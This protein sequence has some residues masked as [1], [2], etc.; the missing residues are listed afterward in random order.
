MIERDRELLAHAPTL[1]RQLGIVVSN[2]MNRQDDGE[3][4]ACQLR[5]LGE[6]M[7]RLGT[8]MMNRSVEING[9]VI[10]AA[11]DR[12]IIDVPDQ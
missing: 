10:E 7:T 1:N 5:R 3:L 11:P 9:H 8:D 12:W 2:M 6:A 4:P